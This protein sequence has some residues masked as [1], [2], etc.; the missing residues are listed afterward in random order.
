[1]ID[2]QTYDGLRHAIPFTVGED[3]SAK[4][5]AYTA[6]GFTCAIIGNH[7]HVMKLMPGEEIPPKVVWH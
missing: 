3:F 2:P 4:W 5:S 7:I 1:M 6:D